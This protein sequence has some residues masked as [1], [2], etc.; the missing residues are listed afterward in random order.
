MN[1]TLAA[2]HSAWVK[3]ANTKGTQRSGERERREGIPRVSGAPNILSL[4]GTDAGPV[5]THQ[6]LAEH[7]L[8]RQPQPHEHL[9]LFGKLLQPSR[10]L[11]CL[12]VNSCSPRM[13]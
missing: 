12:H 5:P 9:Q 7:L 3:R 13:E 10:S 11:S 1:D 2:R 6:R 4:G 8:R